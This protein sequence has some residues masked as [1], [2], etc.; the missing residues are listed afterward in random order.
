LLSF[1]ASFPISQTNEMLNGNNQ[2]RH[3]LTIKPVINILNDIYEISA[4]QCNGYSRVAG[5]K[6]ISPVQ[7]E[8]IFT[9]QAVN[10]KE[11]NSNNLN[12]EELN[13]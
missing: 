1:C 11:G 3:V 13:E 6:D 9:G 10:F 7:K 8:N 5:Q 4:V 12:G 2:Q